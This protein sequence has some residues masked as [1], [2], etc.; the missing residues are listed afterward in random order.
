M[1]DVL[2]QYLYRYLKD[3]H[4]DILVRLEDEA[5]VIDYLNQQLSTVTHLLIREGIPGYIMEAECMEIL[6]ADLKP[7]KYLYIATILEEEFAADYAVFIS[8]GVLPFE[9]INMMTHC[10]YVFDWIGF[11]EDNEDDNFLRYLIIGA[12]S[13]CLEGNREKETVDNELQQP[14]KANR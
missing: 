13:E 14:S 11:T 4:P 2:R 3:N 10:N 8:L 9:V 5:M 12:V 6:T 7:S 1:Q